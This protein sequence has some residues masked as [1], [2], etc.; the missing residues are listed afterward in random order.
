[1]ITV[2][3]QCDGRGRYGTGCADWNELPAGETIA[4]AKQVARRMGWKFGK[5]KWPT[6]L[7]PNCA[8]IESEEAKRKKAAA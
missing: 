2:E 3:I 1:M 4:E 8:W 7:C 6:H 5:G